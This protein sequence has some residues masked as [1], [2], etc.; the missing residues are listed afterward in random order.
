MTHR[1]VRKPL[2][3]EQARSRFLRFL[4]K[5]LHLIDDDETFFRFGA[6]EE[7]VSGDVA[8]KAYVDDWRIETRAKALVF[9]KLARAIG[10]LT[11]K[12]EQNIV[13]FCK[14]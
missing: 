4:P 5:I 8:K 11:D 1:G 2:F 14:C 6:N 13:F 9:E 7:E 3:L 12:L 10:D